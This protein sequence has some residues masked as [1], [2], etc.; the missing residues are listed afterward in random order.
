VVTFLIFFR[1][2]KTWKATTMSYIAII[3]PVIALDPGLARP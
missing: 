3:T 1:L 2:L